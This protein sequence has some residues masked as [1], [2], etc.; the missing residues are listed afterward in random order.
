MLLSYYLQKHLNIYYQ[1]NIMEK[2]LKYLPLIQVEFLN[3][4]SYSSIVL[5]H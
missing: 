5:V 4:K 3:K 1:N 2:H